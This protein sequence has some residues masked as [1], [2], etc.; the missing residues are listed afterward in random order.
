MSFVASCSCLSN[1]LVK[2]T[3]IQHVACALACL[4]LKSF[5]GCGDVFWKPSQVAVTHTVLAQLSA[6]KGQLKKGVMA[7]AS[8]NFQIVQT[9]QA[10]LKRCRN[11]MSDFF[12]V[13]LTVMEQDPFTGYAF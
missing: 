3:S 12:A 5:A 10:M 11:A 4:A 1:N 9:W 8:C 13:K 6:L 7:A 2:D